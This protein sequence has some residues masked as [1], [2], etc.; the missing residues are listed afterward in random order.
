MYLATDL[1][2]LIMTVAEYFLLST[3]D[4]QSISPTE[5]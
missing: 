4:Q 3:G 5:V 2:Q 1:K